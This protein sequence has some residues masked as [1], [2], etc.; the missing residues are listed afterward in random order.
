MFTKTNLIRYYYFINIYI[1][2]QSR[3]FILMKFLFFN[4]SI[5]KLYEFF[6]HFHIWF[7]FFY[8]VFLIY[9]FCFFHLN[10]LFKTIVH[11]NYNIAFFLILQFFFLSSTSFCF[12]S[13]SRCLYCSRAYYCFFS[14]YSLERL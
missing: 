14:F 10:Q 6:T 12:S 13:S 2:Y 8:N 3:A 11:Y 1:F 9:N 7:Q 5:F 4:P